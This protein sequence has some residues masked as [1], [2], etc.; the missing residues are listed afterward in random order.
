MKLKPWTLALLSLL[1]LPALAAN[2]AAEPKAAEP[3]PARKSGASA[4][5]LDRKLRSLSRLKAEDVPTTPDWPVL[6]DSTTAKARSVEEVAQR[7]VAV[8]FTA[9]KAEGASQDT[10][11]GLVKRYKAKKFFTP[12]EFEFVDNN[13]QT[14][15]DRN[16]Y[17]WRY[18]RLWVLMWAL[19]YVEEMD[20]PDRT[21]DV[22]RAVSYLSSRTIEQFIAEA[23]LRDINELLDEADLM[24]RYN[25][26]SED[27]RRRGQKAP[28]GLDR[29]VVAERWAILG[30]LI[31]QH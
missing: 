15:D 19:G 7:A 17:L 18:E 16:K 28:A 14:N 24:Y 29:T 26:A 9:L 2:E 10:M 5:S 11:N 8:C 13:A 4:E 12:A 27:A 3:A 30:W 21:C 25:G 31:G 23:K 6:P 22:R 1:T 20:R